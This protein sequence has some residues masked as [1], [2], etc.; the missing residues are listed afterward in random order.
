[1]IRHA[2]SRIA[3]CVSRTVADA[4]Y[5]QRRISVLAGAPDRWVPSRDS[6][7]ETYAEFMFRTSGPLLHEPA[8]RRR[9]RGR[10]VR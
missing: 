3:R 7:P 4:N 2:A 5:A 6:A 8:A 1:M 9:A 10:T